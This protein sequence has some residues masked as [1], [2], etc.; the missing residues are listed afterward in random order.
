M[1]S[2]TNLGRY[3]DW[4]L[5][6]ADPANAA[7]FS[8][9]TGVGGSGNATTDCVDTGPYAVLKPAYFGNFDGG[10]PG[11]LTRRFNNDV[12]G[13]SD[14]ASGKMHGVHYSSEAIASIMK[15]STFATFSTSLENE[16]HNAFHAAIGGD[17]APQTSPNGT[18]IFWLVLITLI[19][20][21]MPNED[22]KF[23]CKCLSN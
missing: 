10:A 5:I 21:N 3:L 22:L 17:M 15:N 12:D 13:V 23:T 4:T 11:C 16:P 18:S 19:N 20:S 9:V 1:S 14:D 7:V 6:S 2:M 8:P